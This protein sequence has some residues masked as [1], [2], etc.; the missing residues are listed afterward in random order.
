MHPLASPMNALEEI[1]VRK[2][3]DIPDGQPIPYNLKPCNIFH[4]NRLM[5]IKH[6]RTNS[7]TPDGGNSG[8]TL[9][10]ALE[11]SFPMDNEVFT[12]VYKITPYGVIR[13]DLWRESSYVELCSMYYNPGLNV[14]F[15]DV[16]K[17]IELRKGAK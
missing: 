1:E 3:F 6:I 7:P 14:L 11:L 10:I 16:R 2:M 12:R 17:L 15:A 5:D 13:F 9:H 4:D 8:R